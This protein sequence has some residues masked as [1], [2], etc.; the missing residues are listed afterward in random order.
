MKFFKAFKQSWLRAKRESEIRR[1]IWMFRNAKTDEEKQKVVDRMNKK[2]I[3]A[4]EVRK[5]I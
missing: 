5:A 3:S 1:I 2:G 4:E